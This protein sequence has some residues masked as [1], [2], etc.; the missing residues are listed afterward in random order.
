MQMSQ[1]LLSSGNAKENMNSIYDR[2]A[3]LRSNL[4]NNFLTP[5]VGLVSSGQLGSSG[6]NGNNSMGHLS[7]G[8][9]NYSRTGGR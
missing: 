8:A 5:K 7:S 1:N 9:L 2:I 4:N 6:L 3:N